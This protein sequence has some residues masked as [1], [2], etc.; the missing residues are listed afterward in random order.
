MQGEKEGA[1]REGWGCGKEQQVE[2]QAFAAA[3]ENRAVDSGNEGKSDRASAFAAACDRSASGHNE[4]ASERA[5]TG[6]G[7]QPS[8]KKKEP[9]VRGSVVGLR[10]TVLEGAEIACTDFSATRER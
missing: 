1:R 5:C 9:V 10:R 6:C 2:I 7:E 4:K 8:E 3:C